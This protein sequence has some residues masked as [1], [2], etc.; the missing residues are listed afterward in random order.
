MT[1]PATLLDATGRRIVVQDAIGGDRGPLP[2]GR[3]RAAVGPRPGRGPDRALPTARRGSR[4]TRSTS[5]GPATVPAP[6]DPARAADG[7]ARVAPRDVSGRIETCTSSATAGARSSRVGSQLVPSSA[8]RVRAS[9]YG[10]RR[11]PH[12]R[13]SPGS[14]AGRTRPRRTAGSRSCRASRPT[15]RRPGG[16]DVRAAAP[17]ASQRRRRPALRHRQSPS[18]RQPARPRR[19]RPRA[20]STRTSSTSLRSRATGAGRRPRRRPRSRRVHARRR[21]GGRAWSCTGEAADSAGPHRARRRDQRDRPGRGRRTMAGRRRRRRPGGIVVRAATRS[22][23]AAPTAPAP[24]APPTASAPPATVTGG[25]SR[26]PGRALA[27][28]GAAPWPL[29]GRRRRRGHAAP[30]GTPSARSP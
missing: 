28:L 26:T 4:P 25:L 19:H 24:T 27:T 17:V 14:S 20:P 2:D 23:A 18:A 15:C 22:P 1:A 10:A 16:S 30:R 21:H 8:S 9:P 29:D 7:G 5:A 12:R 11:G 3:R 6:L 13:R